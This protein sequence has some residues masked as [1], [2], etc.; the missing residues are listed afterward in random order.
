LA[1]SAPRDGAP[2]EGP[3]RLVRLETVNIPAFR[4]ED[5][6]PPEDELKPE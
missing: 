1:I 6:M 2:K 5:Y 3:D 4:T